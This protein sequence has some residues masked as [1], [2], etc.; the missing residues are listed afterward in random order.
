MNNLNFELLDI[1]GAVRETAEA[2]GFDRSDFLKKGAI[3]GGGLIAGGALFGPYLDTAEAAISRR[4]SKKNDIRI[5]NFALTLEF[6]EADFYR[7]AKSNS[8]SGTDPQLQRYTEWVAGHEAQHVRFLQGAIRAQGGRPGKKPNFEFG[9]RVTDVAKYRG[10]AQVLEDI[11]VR[12]YLGQASRI[13][14][15]KLLTAAGSILAIEA[16]HS[17]WIRFINAPSVA[18]TPTNVLPAPTTFDKPATEGA[19]LSKARAFIN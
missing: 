3:A 8:V 10:T 5:L 18:D 11:G 12:A 7:M 17:S 14:Q 9:D 6:L 16:R 13:L 1:D 2:A 19:T 4:K 15:P